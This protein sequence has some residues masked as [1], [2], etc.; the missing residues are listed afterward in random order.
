MMSNTL[1]DTQP[2]EKVRW[3]WRNTRHVSLSL[4]VN[5]FPWQWR[6]AIGRS[7]N[8]FA[9]WSGWIEFGPFMI[10]L[11]CDIGNVSSGDW[12][13]RFAISEATA[14]NRC[15]AVSRKRGANV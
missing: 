8:D 2:K 10:S 14:W 13:A 7:Q 6:L 5:V 1:D 15:V 4:E 9:G 12:R 11:Y 3:A